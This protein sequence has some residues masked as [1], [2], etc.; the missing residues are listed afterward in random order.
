MYGDVTE[1]QHF[2]PLPAAV[3]ELAASK[4][5]PM[6]RLWGCSFCG[7]QFNNARSH[8]RHERIHTGE[9]PFTC[10]LCGIGTTRKDTLRTHCLR[11]HGMTAEQ[12]AQQVQTLYDG[13]K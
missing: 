13:I 7:Q 9:R 2:P 6:P 5:L 10:P 11:Q 1:Q 4:P 12:Y 8:R 3:R